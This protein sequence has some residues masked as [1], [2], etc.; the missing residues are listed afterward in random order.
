[1]TDE[2]AQRLYNY[3]TMASIDE[4]YACEQKRQQIADEALTLSV[5]ALGE[6]MIALDQ[7]D[8][9][10]ADEIDKMAARM[11]QYVTKR[12]IIHDTMRKMLSGAGL[13]ISPKEWPRFPEL[14]GGSHD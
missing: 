12:R 6:A 5:S 13:A 8:M 9:K 4:D 10:L 14:N 1:M 3:A 2:K 7:E 11:R